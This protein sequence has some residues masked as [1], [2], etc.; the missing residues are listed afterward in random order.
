MSFAH[1]NFLRQFW[2]TNWYWFGQFQLIIKKYHQTQNGQC[3]N[4]SLPLN[5]K[6]GSTCVYYLFW[7][8]N[9]LEAKH[10]MQL[11]RIFLL[12]SQWPT[13]LNQDTSSCLHGWPLFLLL[14][15]V[16]WMVYLDS[17][18]LRVNWN[19]NNTLFTMLSQ[20]DLGH[21]PWQN[22]NWKNYMVV[23]ISSHAQCLLYASFARYGA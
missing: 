8:L 7:M 10:F 12:N 5:K 2:V 21:F 15:L 13:L 16:Y 4:D 23:Y 1:E 22:V 6:W 11:E 17:E 14:P 18:G 19:Q 20:K 3:R 9:I